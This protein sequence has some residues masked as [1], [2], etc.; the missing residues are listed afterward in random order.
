MDASLFKKRREYS[1][2]KGQQDSKRVVEPLTPSVSFI[3]LT[4]LNYLKEILN[5][6][7]GIIKIRLKDVLSYHFSILLDVIFLGF[8]S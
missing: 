3:I 7:K 8:F 5:F 4:L 2:K 1:K 6:Q